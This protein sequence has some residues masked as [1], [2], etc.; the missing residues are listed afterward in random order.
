M[1]F[2]FAACGTGTESGTEGGAVQATSIKFAKEVY[3]VA[4]DDYVLVSKDIKIEPADAEVDYEVSDTSIATINK[5]GEVTGVKEGTVTVT[6]KSKDGKVTATA[7]LNVKGFGTV[8]SHNEDM[9]GDGIITKRAVSVEWNPDRGAIIVFVSKNVDKNIDKTIVKT[10]DYGTKNEDGQYINSGDGFY[11]VRNN[12]EGNYIVENVPAGE[13]VGLII[14]S[15]SEYEG[16]ITYDNSTIAS[17]LKATKLSECLTDAEIEAIAGCKAIQ[18]RKFS[19]QEFVVKANE[20]TVLADR[21]SI[22][23]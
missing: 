21:F 20:H 18:S 9:T 4:V 23:S 19:V 13:Y 6:A 15:N 22:D 12:D 3:D 5:K 16:Y 17:R 7:T 8:S 2:S 10:L 1:L 11:V 14:C